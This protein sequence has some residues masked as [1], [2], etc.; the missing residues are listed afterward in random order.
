M[1]RILPL[2]SAQPQRFTSAKRSY[3]LREELAVLHREEFGNGSMESVHRRQAFAATDSAERTERERTGKNLARTMRS[4]Q[5][6]AV[7]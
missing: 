5:S 7:G 3:P 4:G 1:T 6:R 2:N